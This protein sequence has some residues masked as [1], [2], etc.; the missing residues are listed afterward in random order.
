MEK[1]VRLSK[2]AF[3]AKMET[4]LVSGGGTALVPPLKG[5]T[6]TKKLAPQ[7][8]LVDVKSEFGN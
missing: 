3:N 8:G 2:D 1:G 4:V 6:K 7:E 5:K